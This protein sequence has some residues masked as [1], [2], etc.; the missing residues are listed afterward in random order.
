MNPAEATYLADTYRFTWINEGIEILV[1]RLQEQRGD[2][3]CEMTVRVTV[4]FPDLLRQAKFNLSAAR[5]RTEWA[6]D[7][8]RRR[9]VAEIDWFAAIEQACTL[10][11][12]RWREGTPFIDL[13]LVEPSED[14]AY[15]L[16]PYIIEGAASGIFA[17]GGTGKSLIAL[18]AALSIATGEP[19]LGVVPSRCCPVLYLDWEWDEVAHAERLQALCLGSLIEVPTEMLFYRREVASIEQTAPGIR[20]FVATHEIGLVIVDSLGFARGG[21]PESADLTIKTFAVFR[22]FGVPVLFVDHIAKHA[23]DRAHSFGSVYTRNSARLMWRLD[24]E[25]DNSG[26]RR[27][28]LVNTKWNRRYQRPRGL[29]LSVEMDEQ[30]RLI[31]VKF[32]D[33]EPPLATLRTAGYKEAVL[34]ALKQNPEGLTLQDLRLVLEMESVKISQNVLHATLGR[35][36]NRH[37]FDYREGKWYSKLPA[38]EQSAGEVWDGVATRLESHDP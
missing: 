3:I 6:N 22:S 7:L 17:D 5:T 1:D 23:L 10:S 11:L 25:E 35:K 15:L 37:L 38:Q 33:C 19:V 28:G 31:S 18:A 29:L 9:E 36:S 24:A 8:T 14:D 27:I 12:R 2:L 34:A 30:E 4:P 32:Q 26:S 20:R 21:E 13:G 16:R